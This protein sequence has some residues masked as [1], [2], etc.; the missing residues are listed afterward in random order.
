MSS[1]NQLEELKKSID[2]SHEKPEDDKLQEATI[3]KCFEYIAGFPVDRHLFCD[4][5]GYHAGIHGL[6]LFSFPESDALSWYKQKIGTYLDSC[7]KCIYMFHQGRASLREKFLSSREL[8]YSSVTQFTQMILDW[9]A[10]RLVP[11][12]QEACKQIQMNQGV[13]STALI[14]N[15][16]VILAIIEC[17]CGPGLF[18]VNYQL[19]SLFSEVFKYLLESKTP[20]K[21][22]NSGM[23][24]AVIFFLFEGSDLE[25]DWAINTLSEISA[26][27]KIEPKEFNSALEEELE[28][29]LYE[30]QNPE[31]YNDDTCI[32]FWENM[33]LIINASTKDT[34]LQKLQGPNNMSHIQKY[35]TYKL[36]SLTNILKN[37]VMSYQKIPL[38]FILRAFN[39]LLL[40]LESSFWSLVKPEMFNNFLAT[41]FGNPYYLKYII[42][43]NN[44]QS[45]SG[46]SLND[47]LYWVNPLYK[48]IAVSQQQQAGTTVSDFFLKLSTDKSVGIPQFTR[49]L[50]ISVACDLLSR[51]LKLEVPLYDLNFTVDLLVRV[52]SRSLVDKHSDLFI[53][54]CFDNNSLCSGDENSNFLK[55]SCI[56][57]VSRCLQFDILNFSQ[58]SYNSYKNSNS[59]LAPFSPTLWE[60]MTNRNFSSR[61]FLHQSFLMTKLLSSLKGIPGILVIKGDA[62]LKDQYSSMLLYLNNLLSM[63]SEVSPQQLRIVLKDPDALD[64]LWSSILSPEQEISQSATSIL[65]EAYDSS[66]RFEGIRSILNENFEYCLKSVTHSLSRTI[67]CGFYEPCP[68]AVR[69]LMDVINASNDPITGMLSDRTKFANIKD[70]SFLKE[71]WVQCW[72]FLVFIYKETLK[73][74]NSYDSKQL[75]EFTRDTLDLSHLILNCFTNISTILSLSDSSL[76]GLVEKDL[77]QNIL[78]SFRSMLVWLRLSDSALLTLCVDLIIKAVDLAGELNLPFSDDVVELLAK[79]GCKAKKFNNKL[80]DEQVSEILTRARGL[81]EELVEKV[82]G[83]AEEYRK[84]T[85]PSTDSSNNSTAASTPVPSIASS[86]NYSRFDSHKP[87]KELSKLDRIKMDIRQ[88]RATSSSKSLIIHP[89]SKS[90]F[91]S[92]RGKKDDDESDSDSDLDDGVRELFMK[93]KKEK[94]K[95][96]LL[97]KMSQNKSLKL[98]RPVASAADEQ[99]KKELNMRRRLNVSLDPLYRS[100]LSWTYNRVSDFPDERGREIYQP[101]RDNFDNVK[102]YQKTFE[103]LLLLECW[104]SIVQSRQ[105]TQEKPFELLIGT[106]ASVDNFFDVYASIEKSV[107][108]DRKI[109]ESDLLVLGYVRNDGQKVENMTSRVLEETSISCL[110]KVREIKSA[111]SDYADIT[112]RVMPNNNPMIPIF[113]PQTLVTG[114]KVMQ[115]VTIEREYSSLFGLQYYDL[116]SNIIKAKPTFEENEDKSEVNKMISTFKVNESQAAAIIGS[117]RNKGF[118]LIQGPPGTGKTKTILGIVGYI[119]TSNRSSSIITAPQKKNHLE[120]SKNQKILICAPSNAAVDELVLRL[121]SKIKDSEG[122]DFQPKVVRLGRSDAI[123]SAVKDLT[124]EELVDKELGAKQD[125]QVLSDGSIRQE[126]N[127]CLQER[128]S[129]RA[130]LNQE[131]L[132]DDK[133]V[134]LQLK[135]REITKKKNELGRALDEQREKVSVSYRNKEIERRNIQFKILSNANI[136]CSTLSGSAHDLVKGMN[137]ICDT[138]IIDE[139]CQCTELS[140]IIPLRYGCE[141]CIMVGDPNQLPPT[142]LSQTAASYNYEQSLFVRMHKNY[143]NSVYLL[144]VQYRMHPDI[145]RFPSDEFYNSKLIDGNKMRELNTR[146]WHSIYPLS[147]YR[148]FDIAG[149]QEQSSRSKSF[150]NTTEAVVALEL[151]KKLEKISVKLGINIEGKIGIISPYKEQ[152]G[153]L[154]SVFIR[155]YGKPILNI[156]DFNTVDGFQGQEKEVI[157]MSCVR[158]S[159]GSTVGFLADVRRMNVGLTRAKTTLWVLGHRESLSVN[160]VWNHLIGDADKRGLVSKASPGFLKGE[161]VDPGKVKSG[162]IP[163]SSKFIEDVTKKSPKKAKS[164]SREKDK[165]KSKDKEKS[166]DKVKNKDKDKTK[167]KGKDKESSKSEEKKKKKKEKDKDKTVG[168]DNNA[169]FGNDAKNEENALVDNKIHS[170]IGTAIDDKIG[171]SSDSLKR[172]PSSLLKPAGHKVQK[173]SLFI[174]KNSNKSG[175]TGSPTINTASD[176]RTNKIPPPKRSGAITNP[177]ATESQTHPPASFL[178]NLPTAPKNREYTGSNSNSFRNAESNSSNQ[179]YGNNRFPTKPGFKNND[180]SSGFKNSDYN[181]NPKHGSPGYFGSGY[182][183]QAAN[184]NSSYQGGPPDLSR[185]NASNYNSYQY[186]NYNSYGNYN[187]YDNSYNN[188]NYNNNPQY[189]RNDSHNTQTNYNNN[190]KP[191]NNSQYKNNTKNDYR[192]WKRK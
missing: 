177:A 99:K 158:A 118:S 142:V 10:S 50:L 17:L 135:I 184:R 61:S 175:F 58:N 64:G 147:P 149:R 186:G 95:A 140:V 47:L 110:A 54:T 23:P 153:K 179:K 173:S 33:V 42:E 178:L 170:D 160:K 174:K 27:K 123:N 151:V 145:S 103:P 124:L 45:S 41:I 155:H 57:L 62:K 108:Y 67:S 162:S 77:F 82:T 102:D 74:A 164:K 20:F 36:V 168:D 65:Y 48:S 49:S 1:A 16:R 116:F 40:K 125:D 7:Q 38:P 29:H 92:K 109:G 113:S 75:V 189:N 59:S 53:S 187:N 180:H 25:K 19:R 26:T 133:A 68:R 8:D 188:Y 88:N 69:V 138:V 97:D 85:K 121:R 52:E 143:P 93:N 13:E 144:N 119:L 127:K 46:A 157:I 169:H 129:I 141:K 191:F 167:N 56:N 190:S 3:Q 115:M 51:C 63:F 83:E 192:N 44:N 148:F 176:K 79:Y 6:I 136:I 89:P 15:N 128:D 131:D 156:I 91:H 55:E 181:Q 107:L 171:G 100:V 112:L 104:Q 9:E 185:N 70:K 134:Q 163:Q 80:T 39:S 139:A 137:I 87:E 43:L 154:K 96:T 114:L 117:V 60:K 32:K 152:I 73:W 130:Q 165:T 18:R 122:N 166:K 90:G 159:G 37:H 28:M 24:A 30:I 94:A 161:L 71:F 105:L 132:P 76:R 11:I 120:V 182:P 126:L 183:N 101:V 4:A 98:K 146:A 5:E 150:F 34:V 86:T 22:S 2:A 14:L 12:F 172:K 72:D 111:N 21:F 66:G 35:F 81:N 31:Y 78:D 84:S 106:R